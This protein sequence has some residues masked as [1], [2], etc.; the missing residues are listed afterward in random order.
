MIR[1]DSSQILS[2]VRVPAGFLMAGLFFYLSQPTRRSL[3]IGAGVAFLGILIRGWATGHIRKNDEL[4]VT[5]PYAFT[6]NPLYFGSFIIGL[7]FCLAGARLEILSVFLIS[8]VALY[9]NVMQQE[10][11][12][13]RQKFPEDYAK[14]A[15]SVPL[16][17]PRLIAGRVGAGRFSFKRYLKNREYQALLGFAGAVLV[18]FLK[19]QSG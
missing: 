14:Y 15:A 8:F 9:G 11:D 12:F 13:L 6:R 19:I 17:F 2:R 4:T 1:F 10:L 16:F 7:G 18:L 3:W 5:G